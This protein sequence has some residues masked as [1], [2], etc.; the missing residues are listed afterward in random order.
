MEERSEYL[1]SLITDPK[2]IKEA[3]IKAIKLLTEIAYNLYLNHVTLTSGQKANLLKYKKVLQSL[4]FNK[5]SWSQR[6]QLLIKNK[7]VL[8]PLLRPVRHMLT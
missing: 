3:D 6:K 7:G 5:G 2:R 8:P 1:K 4:L